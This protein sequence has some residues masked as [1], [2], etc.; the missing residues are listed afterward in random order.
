MWGF[1]GGGGPGKTPCSPALAIYPCGVLGTATET[2]T[3]HTTAA[4][5]RLDPSMTFRSGFADGNIAFRTSSFYET[6]C[7]EFLL[8]P[9][10]TSS[11]KY[12]CLDPKSWKSSP[13]WFTSQRSIDLH[14]STVNM[15]ARDYALTKLPVALPTN[16]VPQF[17]DFKALS[18]HFEK[19]LNSLNQDAFVQD[20]VWR[21]NFIMTGT[22][23]TFYSSQSIFAAWQ[24]TASTR[25]PTSFVVEG[26]P[27]PRP[28]W[29]DLGFTFRT[30]GT[31]AASGH[32]YLSIVP[33]TDGTWKIWVMKTVLEKLD[34]IPDVDT[35]APAV[36]HRADSPLSNAVDA[37]PHVNGSTGTEVATTNGTQTSTDPDFF[38]TIVIGGGQSGLSVGGRCKA[39][40]INYVVLEKNVDVGDSWSNRYDLTRCRYTPVRSSSTIGTNLG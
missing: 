29:L 24:Q 23:R 13:L 3:F 16:G 33:E 17:V 22:F 7:T 14:I 18:E 9:I 38:E 8:A 12:L 37:V 11:V 40:G 34:S 36:P 1:G 5:S 30:E 31:P 39:L 27:Q 2:S 6:N 19:V 20:A 21:D 28:K 10:Q 35:L 26:L 32:G 25:Q 4:H 15:V